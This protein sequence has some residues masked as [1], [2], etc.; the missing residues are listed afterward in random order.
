MK[1]Y[2]YPFLREFVF[3]FPPLFDF[4]RSVE[5]EALFILKKI[6]K[7]GE[8]I[9][10]IGC[11]C[12]NFTFKLANHFKKADILAY[13]LSKDMI[14]CA[15]LKLREKGF[16]NITF[17]VGDFFEIEIVADIFVSLYLFNLLPLEKAFSKLKQSKFN[18][19][20]ISFTSESLFTVFHKFFY[21]LVGGRIELWGV[22]DVLGLL[23]EKGFEDVKVYEVNWLE[24]SY[25]VLLSG[26][27]Y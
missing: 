18:Y 11:G 20:L 19:A 23:E 9:I 5:K 10:E 22:E 12:G 14:D 26:G 17:K 13:D 4:R 25:L 24:G 21:N 27:V 1:Y 6:L 3:L 7:G 8:R 15:N 2:S 16:G